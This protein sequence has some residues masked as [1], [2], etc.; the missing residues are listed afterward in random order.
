LSFKHRVSR[1]KPLIFKH[2]CLRSRD[3]GFFGR[4]D[5]RPKCDIAD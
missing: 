1:S 3:H 4:P 5:G 2:I